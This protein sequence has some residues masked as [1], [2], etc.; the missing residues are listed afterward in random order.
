[1]GQKK[2]GEYVTPNDDYLSALIT[3]PVV[4]AENYEIKPHFLK[5]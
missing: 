3:K 4:T 5:L 1:M 2:L